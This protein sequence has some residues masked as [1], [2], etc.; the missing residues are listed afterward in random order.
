MPYTILDC[1][2]AVQA[3]YKNRDFTGYQLM[4]GFYDPKNMAV[5]DQGYSVGVY[6]SQTTPGEIIISMRGSAKGKTTK[7]WMDDDVS[8]AIG[9]TPDRAA[10]SL[11]YTLKILET[12]GNP[13]VIIVG[14]SLGGWLAQYAGVVCD[15][16]MISFNAPPAL[17]TFS[18]R[19][20]DGTSAAGYR[21]GLNFRVNYDPVSKTP[22]KHVG[23]LVT[24]PLNGEKHILAHTGKVVVKSVIASG[25]AHHN[26]MTEIAGRN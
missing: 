14:H 17:G 15:K 25:L 13:P 5:G 2:N 22:G 3:I 16:P 6:R 4:Q 12:Y 21:Q 8:I 9:R 20:P 24:L 26:A 1:A 23:P 11:E 19:L 7:D 10:D 18:K